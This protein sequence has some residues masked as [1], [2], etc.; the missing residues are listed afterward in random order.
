[1][2]E[3]EKQVIKKP[4]TAFENL[5]RKELENSY[6]NLCKNKKKSCHD[7]LLGPYCRDT[8]RHYFN[9]EGTKLAELLTAKKVFLNAYNSYREIKEYEISGC[10]DFPQRQKVLPKCVIIGTY[11]WCLEWF[12]NKKNNGFTHKK[13]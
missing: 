12:K 5:T 8:F 13:D 3:Y 4:Y 9:E 10:L 2:K 11:G 1:M 6:C 7:V